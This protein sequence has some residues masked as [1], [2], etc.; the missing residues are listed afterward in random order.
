MCVKQLPT[1]T[2]WPAV[3]AISGGEW[4]ASMCSHTE[5]ALLYQS[6]VS[7]CAVVVHYSVITDRSCSI[8]FGEY[9]HIQRLLAF[10]NAEYSCTRLT[11]TD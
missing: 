4:M 6:I 5:K 1:G 11:C 8:S 10:S 7:W 2:V 3:G 9:I